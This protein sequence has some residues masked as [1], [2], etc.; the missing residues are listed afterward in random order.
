M[1]VEIINRHIED[2]EINGRK[3]GFNDAWLV[4]KGKKYYV[5]SNAIVPMMGYSETLIFKSNKN[6]FV[7]DWCE[8]AGG[9]G[10]THEEAIKELEGREN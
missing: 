10:I 8:V 1:K 9:R 7:S 4:K 2:S 3:C 6:G 5:V